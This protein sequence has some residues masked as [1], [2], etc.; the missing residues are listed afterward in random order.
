MPVDYYDPVALFFEDGFEDHDEW[1][2]MLGEISL[3][4]GIMVS[5]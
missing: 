3:A 1:V 2:L 4:R 5:S